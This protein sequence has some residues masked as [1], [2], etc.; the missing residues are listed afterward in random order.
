MVKCPKC[1]RQEVK[2]PDEG[3]QPNHDLR[4]RDCISHPELS[5]VEIKFTCSECHSNFPVEQ[6]CVCETC[7]R[8]IICFG[9]TL[10]NHRLRSTPQLTE[11]LQKSQKGLD[12]WR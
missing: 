10:K 4:Q 8:R 7:N 5:A 12:S 3:F 6:L 9:C 1:R 11:F 2:I